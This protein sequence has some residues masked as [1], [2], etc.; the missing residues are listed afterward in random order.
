[1]ADRTYS[2]GKQRSIEVFL[3]HF[4]AEQCAPPVHSP[5]AR[6][7]VQEALQSLHDSG[8]RDV[9]DKARKTSRKLAQRTPSREL[10][11]PD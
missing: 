10:V 6:Q 1:M 8:V 5:S 2:S 4:N 7:S 3:S 9:V 11:T